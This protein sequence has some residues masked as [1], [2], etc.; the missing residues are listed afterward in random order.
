MHVWFQLFREFSAPRLSFQ[1]AVSLPVYLSVSFSNIYL[2]TSKNDSPS[3]LTHIKH[4]YVQKGEPNVGQQK[5][6]E[7]SLAAS[8]ATWRLNQD[9]RR[10]P[11]FFFYL[12]EIK[13]HY[14]TGKFTPRLFANSD[15]PLCDVDVLEGKIEQHCHLGRVLPTCRTE[16]SLLTEELLGLTPGEVD[17]CL[18]G[19]FFFLIGFNKTDRR[20]KKIKSCQQAKLT[21][22]QRCR[23][24]TEATNYR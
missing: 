15:P 1:R 23:R 14:C 3:F 24:G 19:S 18:T 13:K 5:K 6:E 22:F 21:V 8:L 7:V 12:Q 4:T 11:F 17:L 16:V 10:P 2:Q 9:I 20:E